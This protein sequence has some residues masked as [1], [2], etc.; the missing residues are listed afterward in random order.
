[1]T[2]EP[3]SY[4]IA[5]A[6]MGFENDFQRIFDDLGISRAELA[7]R[8]KSSPEY[9]TKV[10]NGTT[11]NFQLRTMAKWA[12][13]IGAIVQI[14]LIKEGKEAVRVVDY[15]TAAALDD[16]SSGSERATAADATDTMAT[17]IPFPSAVVSSFR[18]LSEAT[19]S[20]DGSS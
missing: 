12:R 6:R 18:P 7:R 15:E 10:L 19:G 17:I 13:A 8:L 2:D 20:G 16:A 3:P 9:V 11:G 4:W 14:R 5:V 1:M